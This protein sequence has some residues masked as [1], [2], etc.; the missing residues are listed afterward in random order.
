MAAS[1][2]VTV[3]AELILV[4]ILVPVLVRAVRDRTHGA[5]DVALFFGLLEVLLLRSTL[6]LA[7]LPVV[8]LV[9]AALVYALPYLMLRLLVDF[10]RVPRLVVRAAEAAL[11]LLVVSAFLYPGGASPVPP[12]LTAARVAYFVLLFG[13]PAA[14]FLDL[15]RRSSGVTR[16]RMQA[17]SIG[18]VLFALVIAAAGVFA[19]APTVAVAGA[20]VIAPGILATSLAWFLGFAPPTFV[21]RFWQEPELR[22][23]F[24]RTAALPRLT[25]PEAVAREIVDAAEA[26]TG[27]RAALGLWDE[28]ADLM[29]FRDADGAQFAFAPGHFLAWSAVAQRRAHYTEDPARADP[30]NAP[31][32]RER[33]IGAVLAAPLIAGERALGVLVVYASGPL[34]FPRGDLELV[35]LLADQAAVVLESRSLIA[36]AARTEAREEA[37]RLKEDFV[38]AA[39]HDLKTPLTALYGR[40]QLMQR[41]QRQG[42]VP[43]PST[44]DRIVGDARGLIGLVDQLLDASRIGQGR[45]ELRAEPFDLGELARELHANRADWVRVQLRTDGKL[46]SL[47]DRARLEQV[48][49]NLVENALKYSPG[50]R[51]VV[52]SAVRDGDQAH[53]AVHDDGI[54]IP[55]ADLD[56]VFERFRR[57]SNVADRHIAGI[58]LGLFTS[59]GIVEQHGGRIWAES[60]PGTG[61]TLHV[62]LPLHEEN[63]AT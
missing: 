13:Y 35:R 36:A 15:A 21:R 9:S 27:A 25:T 48:I 52:V 12:V 42:E 17:I 41:Q 6:G 18:N 60:E 10:G 2:L 31:M 37:A 1:D 55:Q 14:G 5:I 54:G 20:V 32:Y 62:V 46:P 22:A 39:A 3:A 58:G 47:V 11:V 61:T 23:F 49:D 44:T 33:Q 7:D 59:R 26:A 57:G 38:A 30:E 16:R 4:A 8:G 24:A 50:E 51:P 40:A 28:Q 19:L 45:L 63:A 43:D 56:L 29:R 53:L 34:I